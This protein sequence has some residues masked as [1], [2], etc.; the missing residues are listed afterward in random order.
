MIANAVRRIDQQ[1]PGVWR[2]CV[3]IGSKDFRGQTPYGHFPV[4][5]PSS[6]CNAAAALA[7]CRQL[8]FVEPDEHELS[9]QVRVGHR[10]TA[11]GMHSLMQLVPLGVATLLHRT[12]DEVRLGVLLQLAQI[13]LDAGLHPEMIGDG[14][15]HGD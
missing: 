10:R 11:A 13:I 9:L 3:T 5:A 6:S 15:D 4:I 12:Q 7:S 8:G 14:P 2:P 1:A